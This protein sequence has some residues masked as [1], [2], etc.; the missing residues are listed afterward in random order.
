MCVG[1]CLHMLEPISPSSLLSLPPLVQMSLHLFCKCLSVCTM[2]ECMRVFPFTRPAFCSLCF[3]VSICVLKV[4]LVDCASVV[5]RLCRL[6][7][8]ASQQRRTSSS[9]GRRLGRVSIRGHTSNGAEK[10]K[11][12]IYISRPFE[13]QRSDPLT[14]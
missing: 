13:S 14:P 5:Q 7:H 6:Q 11:K 9:E 4:L 3:Y 12:Y 8:C 10:K 2:C 1:A